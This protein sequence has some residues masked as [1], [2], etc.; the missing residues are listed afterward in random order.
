MNVGEVSDLRPCPWGRTAAELKCVLDTGNPLRRNQRAQLSPN[1]ETVATG[2]AIQMK[3][4]ES[5]KA[6]ANASDY[7]TPRIN[8]DTTVE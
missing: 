7:V 5:F 1:R 6:P 3:P 2:G 8:P 4:G